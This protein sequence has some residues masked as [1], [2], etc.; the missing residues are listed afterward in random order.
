MY[1]V[2]DLETTGLRTSWQDRVIEVAVVH[3]DELGRR[4]GEWCSLVN[5]DRDLGPQHIHGISA[6]EAR[7]APSFEQLAGQVVELL[8]GKVLVAH[9][10]SFDAMFLV[11][12]F[13][14]LGIIAPVEAQGG[15]CT[16]RLAAHFLSSAGRSLQD[17][18]R[19]AGLPPHQAHSALHDA[20]AAAD[21]LACYLRAA[22]SPPPWPD[23]LDRA[24]RL[25]WPAVPASSAVP[26]QRA[27]AGHRRP[28]FLSQLVDRLPRLNE[29]RADAY[30]ELLDQALLDRHIS[31][32]EAD[33]LIAVANEFG[34]ARVDVAAIHEQYLA[35]LSA[36]A[37][38]DGIVTKAERSDLEMVAE[39]LGLAKTSVRGALESAA[40]I[41]ADRANR[42]SWRLQQGD[43]VVFT[44]SMNPSREDWQAKAVAAGLRV[45]GGVTKR[46]RL[47]VA[48]DPDSASG[49]AKK[50]REYHIPIVHPTAFRRMLGT[51]SQ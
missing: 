26:V 5:P 1:S 24:S 47:L 9:N 10:L 37:L 11:A 18:L 41:N 7:R 39:L 43:L 16:M 48:A 31:A 21:L 14:R 34:L 4:Q 40:R 38:S 8:R 42:D 23:V 12:E 30:L 29:P 51:L 35:N 19:V 46:T 49:K 50:A 13:K 33:G 45:G 22:G 36:I 2:I 3:L 25:P 15:L 6:A 28:H 20:R 17:C 44:G 27:A 32:T